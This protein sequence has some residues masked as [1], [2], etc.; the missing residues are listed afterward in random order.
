MT[1]KWASERLHAGKDNMSLK[2]NKTMQTIAY[3]NTI[4]LV[5]VICLISKK[6]SI[7]EYVVKVLKSVP[8]LTLSIS[9]EGVR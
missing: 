6:R 1:N 7:I 5:E 9:N 2:L 3:Y 8:C 4:E